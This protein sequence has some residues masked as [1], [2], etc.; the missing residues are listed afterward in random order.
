MINYIHA[1]Q[2]GLTKLKVG[3]K[4]TLY[5]PSVLAFGDQPVTGNGGITIPA[6]SN[7]LYEVELV[8]IVE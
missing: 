4:A 5:V 7:L 6:N 1:F 8:E 2:A 3:S